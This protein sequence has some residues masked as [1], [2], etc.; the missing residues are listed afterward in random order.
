[1]VLSANK[2]YDRDLRSYSVCIHH[3]HSPWAPRGAL[4]NTIE[5]QCDHSAGLNTRALRAISLLVIE[6]PREFASCGSLALASVLKRNG[7]GEYLHSAR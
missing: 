3:L 2:A 1:M 4:H 7:I 5:V 6:T